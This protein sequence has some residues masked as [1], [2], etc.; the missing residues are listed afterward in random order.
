MGVHRRCK[1]R[2]CIPIGTQ[3][4]LNSN[5]AS[6]MFSDYFCILG[7]SVYK[8]HDPELVEGVMNITCDKKRIFILICCKGNRNFWFLYLKYPTRY[9][10]PDTPRLSLEESEATMMANFD[11]RISKHLSV[12]TLWS[13][14]SKYT[15]VPFEEGLL[16]HWYANR[17]VCQGDA[18]YKVRL[19]LYYGII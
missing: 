3:H 1:Q 8:S 17:I 12:E 10:Y 11:I 7:E 19:Q 16:E 4:R 5:Q 6:G 14:R 15:V 9:Q 18:V 2:F 13:R